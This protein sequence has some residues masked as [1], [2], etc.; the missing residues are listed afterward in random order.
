[1][2]HPVGR[3]LFLVPS[4]TSFVTFLVEA[5]QEWQRRGGTVAVATGPDLQ[6]HSAAAWPPLVERFDMPDTRSGS[7]RD[8]IRAMGRLAGHVRRWKPDVVHAHFAVSALVA[9]ATRSLLPR[10]T[11]VWIA[12]FHGM[13]MAADAPNRSRFAALAERWAARRMTAVCVLNHED[14]QLLASVIPPE[15][16]H[17]QTSCGVG[18]DLTR[19]DRGRFPP[20]ESRRVRDRLGVPDNAFLAVFVGRQVAFKGLDVAVR[21]FRAAIDA[22]LDG[23]LAL[24]GEMDPAHG[25]GLTAAE[26]HAIGN[27]PRILQ[28][29]WQPD[30]APLLAAADVTLLPSVREGMPVSAME[31]LAIG[32]PVITVDSRGC[33]DVV[34]DNVDGIVLKAATPQ[35]VADALLRCRRDREFLA[36]LGQMAIAGRERFDR[37]H[38][39]TEQADFLTHVLAGSGTHDKGGRQR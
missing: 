31:S 1:M 17:L 28:L 34:R 18:C 35:L 4:A 32:T 23:W 12:T 16:I 19:F 13:H 39:A 27:Q 14:Q 20:D 8:L 10:T 38:F 29:G 5:A 21:G 24:V 37:R 30:V 6:G 11:P 15:R 36:R 25:S 7:P 26:W 9:A 3:L 33:R 22:G 2:T